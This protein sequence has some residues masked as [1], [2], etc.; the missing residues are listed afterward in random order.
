MSAPRPEPHSRALRASPAAHLVRGRHEE[1][2]QRSSHW[3]I[4]AQCLCGSMHGAPPSGISLLQSS[5]IGLRR[6]ALRRDNALGAK[7]HP[8][9]PTGRW[10]PSAALR[11]APPGLRL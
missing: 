1:V 9:A 11:R 2:G 7:V 6:G 10:D 5:G 8:Q 3:P 4:H